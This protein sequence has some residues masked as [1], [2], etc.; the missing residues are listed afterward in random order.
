MRVYLKYDHVISFIFQ[1]CKSKDI[2]ILVEKHCN[3]IPAVA[4]RQKILF[5]EAP[6]QSDH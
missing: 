2:H 6:A 1:I 4:L 3:E 5:I